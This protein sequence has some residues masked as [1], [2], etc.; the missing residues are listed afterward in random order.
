MILSVLDQSPIASG[1]TYADALNESVELARQADA[2]GY[3]R[4]WFAEHHNSQGLACSAPEIMIARG[5]GRDQTHPCRLW[6]CDACR[7]MR[8]TRWQSSLRCWRHCIPRR[9][10]LGIGRAPGSDQLTAAALAPEGGAR[11][12]DNFPRQVQGSRGIS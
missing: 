11:S 1:R 3:H 10:D 6:R 9:I 7:T 4:Y 12:V 5:G 8:H 2:S